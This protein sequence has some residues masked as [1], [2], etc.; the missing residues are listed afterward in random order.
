MEPEIFELQTHQGFVGSEQFF[1]DF[2]LSFPLKGVTA[3]LG[4]SGVGKSTLLKALAGLLPETSLQVKK[5]SSC[6]PMALMAQQDLLLPWSSVLE[7]CLLGYKLRGELRPEHRQRAL[8]LLEKVGLTKW[9]DAKPFTLSGGMR[10]RVALVRTFM[11]NAPL[12]L[13]DEPFSA[14]DLVNRHQLQNLAAELFKDKTVVM[15]THDPKEALRLANQIIVLGKFPAEICYELTLDS[16]IP[17]ATD[18]QELLNFEPILIEQLLQ[19]VMHE[20]GGL[21]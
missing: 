2:K 11:E 5:P 19:S 18:S 21:G 16:S 12:I 7:N 20:A 13:M 4:A 10:Q 1:Q 8:D 3:I 6:S 14:L 15:V 17:R 9:K